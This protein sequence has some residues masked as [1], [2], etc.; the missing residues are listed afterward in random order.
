VRGL[1][2]KSGSVGAGQ[3]FKKGYRVGTCG[4]TGLIGG[5]AILICVI[6]IGKG[7]C[8]RPLMDATSCGGA[9]ISLIR[10]TIEQQNTPDSSNNKD[11]C[12]VRA[13]HR[14]RN[15][16]ASPTGCCATDHLDQAWRASGQVLKFILVNA[17]QL[18]NVQLCFF[19]V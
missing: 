5:I 3:Q 8:G 14:R 4:K 13:S 16:T 18:L 19:I 9:P 15:A 7:C 17:I 6:A 10:Q 12:A 1:S 11:G 2:A